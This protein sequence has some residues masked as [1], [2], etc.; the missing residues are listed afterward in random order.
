MGNRTES[1]DKPVNEN[2][3]PNL[4]LANQEASG[5]PQGKRIKNY[6]QIRADL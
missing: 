4:T 2:D 1:A 3:K 6:R 5:S